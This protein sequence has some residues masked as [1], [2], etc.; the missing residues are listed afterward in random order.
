VFS[1]SRIYGFLRQFSAGND[2]IYSLSSGLLVSIFFYVL[3]VW[4][5][6][7]QKRDL[8]KNRFRREWLSFKEE[9]IALFLG[10]SEGSCDVDLHRKLLKQT[11]FK[12]FFKGH[13]DQYDG[14]RW[15]YIL[16][17]VN[18]ENLP[19]ILL[20]MYMLQREVEVVL[21]NV[22][23]DDDVYI[24]F[25]VL[26]RVVYKLKNTKIAYDDTK[27]LAQVLWQLFTGW[28]FTE[29]YRPHDIIESMIRR[30]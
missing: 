29:G 2:I 10:I 21:N 28:S 27:E 19:E 30:I 13:C 22:D 9:M 25:K 5:P 11:E 20:L 3:V 8:I 24:M 12:A 18:E 16:N 1:D 17:K 4:L 15:E 6:A 26:S 14:T 7:R 23:M